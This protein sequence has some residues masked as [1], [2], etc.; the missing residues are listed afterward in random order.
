MHFFTPDFGGNAMMYINLIWAWGHPEVY[1]L[2][3]PAFGIFSEVVA[4]FSRKRLFG[5]TSMVWALGAI[6]FLSFVVWLHHFFTMGAGPDVN[7][8]FGIMT[9]VIAVPT[10][11]KVFNWLFTMYRGRIRLTTPML[12]FLGFIVTFSIGGATGVLMSV[13]AIDFQVH[14]S[15]FLVAHFHNMIIG[16]VIFG[17]FAG[18]TYWF[19]KIFGFKLNERLGTY[20]FVCW[21]S[22]FL[23]AFM[24]L[25]VLGLMGATRR[26]DHYDESLGWQGLFIVSAVGVG[27]IMLGAAFQ[28]LQLVISIKDRKKNRDVSGDPWD[29]RTLEWATTSPA[30]V[31]NFAVIPRVET[32]DAFWEMKQSKLGGHK[33]VYENIMLPKNSP[34]PVMIAACVAVLGFSIIWHIWWLVFLALLC[35]IALVIRRTSDDESEYVLSAEEI[36]KVEASHK[37]RYA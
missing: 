2:I 21:I 24:P 29:G 13:P 27:L 34:F 18:L 37:R 30:P 9:A 15:L 19:P 7:A 32:R 6:T 25:Y 14:N 35:A 16:G 23:L 26:L 28:A 3:L 5:Y 33:T 8:F 10:G 1:I 36:K 17:Y 4:T 31:Y 22:G 11:V 12:W 20:A